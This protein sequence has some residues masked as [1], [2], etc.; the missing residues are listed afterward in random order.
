MSLAK[1]HILFYTLQR[2]KA[3]AEVIQRCDGM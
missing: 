1:V 2:A 3:P